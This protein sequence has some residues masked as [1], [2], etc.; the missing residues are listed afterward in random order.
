VLVPRHRQKLRGEGATPSIVQRQRSPP[1]GTLAHEPGVRGTMPRG[2]SG[3]DGHGIVRSGI[4]QSF[5]MTLSSG[6]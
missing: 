1:T 4:G 3:D 2:T 5:L 6:H